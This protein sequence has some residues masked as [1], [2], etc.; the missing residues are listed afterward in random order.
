MAIDSE[1]AQ[2]LRTLLAALGPNGRDPLFVTRSQIAPWPPSLFNALLETGLF[3]PAGSANIMVCPGCDH[4][5]AMNVNFD[6]HPETGNSRAFIVCDRRDDMGLIGLDPTELNQWQL[7]RRQLADFLV[8]TLALA[9]SNLSVE[10]PAIALG[11]TT[12]KHGRR[13][14][15]LQFEGAPQLSIDHG[16]IPLDQLL[17]WN[18]TAIAV[19]HES[20][21]LI[22]DQRPQATRHVRSI[23]RREARKLDTRDRHLRWQKEY[24]RLKQ[25]KPGW[26]DE[27]IADFI[28]ESDPG[29]K[30][31]AGTV[32]RYMKP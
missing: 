5:C 27:A 1:P 4:A 29:P 19:D 3:R 14:V 6:V 11:W 32:R 12:S 17:F 28:A 10:A 24:R 20:F 13:H 21:R 30:R 23:A 18:G 31:R 22:A 15:C 25:E 7:S 16:S 8:K 2:L 26:S 9:P